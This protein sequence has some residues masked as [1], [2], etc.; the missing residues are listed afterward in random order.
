[1]WSGWVDKGEKCVKRMIKGEW[2]P[3]MRV[4]LDC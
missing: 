2:Q 1:M 3:Q 4:G